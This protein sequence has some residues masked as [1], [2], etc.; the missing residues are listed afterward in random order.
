MNA[1][2]AFTKKE[3]LEYART[4]KLLIAAAVFVLFG[5]IN[6]ITAKLTP[7]L[8]SAM[9]PE[10]IVISLPEPSA[11][12][13]WMQ[14]YNNMISLQIIVFIVVFS[15]ITANELSRGTLVNMLTKGL[16]RK[17]V[18]FSKFTALLAVWTLCYFLCFG[19]TYGYTLYLLPGSLSHLFFAALCMWLYGILLLA[20]MLL[21]GILAAN[22]Y[23][24]LLLTGGFAILLILLDFI[25]GVQKYNPYRLA[26]GN[27]ELLS[28]N[29]AVSDMLLPAGIGFGVIVLAITAALLAFDKKAL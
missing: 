12:D 28:G 11:L 21:G 16:S 5:F 8:L 4:Y 2:F 29:M 6:P 25:P 17:T 13:A 22:I 27:V 19:L 26:S 3:F 14:F 15:G 1:Y 24:S 23:G 20:V 9:M 7:E 18:I 10:N